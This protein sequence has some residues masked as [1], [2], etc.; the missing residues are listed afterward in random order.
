MTTPND[1]TISHDALDAVIAGYMLAVDHDRFDLTR[2]ER[3]T[4]EAERG[5]GAEAAAA[6]REALA[7]WRGPPLADLEYEPLIQ[8]TNASARPCTA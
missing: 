6:L 3:L 2:F 1:P 7:L 5:V 8:R 4:G